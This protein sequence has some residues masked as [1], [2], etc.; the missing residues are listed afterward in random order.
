M[1]EYE[2][3]AVYPSPFRLL[4]GRKHRGVR[5]KE[6]VLCMQP[7]QEVGFGRGSMVGLQ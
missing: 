6:F 7:S 4:G 1:G 2:G 5:W 3:L